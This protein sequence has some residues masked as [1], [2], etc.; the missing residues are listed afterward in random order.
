M[1]D[2]GRYPKTLFA[3]VFA[4]GIPLLMG[5]AVFYFTSGVVLSSLRRSA[6]LSTG[7]Q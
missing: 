4:G 3:A 5:A 7:R 6:S 2:D 1:A